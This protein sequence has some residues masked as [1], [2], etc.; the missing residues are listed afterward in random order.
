MSKKQ[1]PPIT[2]SSIIESHK[3]IDYTPPKGKFKK[4]LDRQMLGFPQ[5][6][7]KEDIY[8]DDCN[9]PFVVDIIDSDDNIVGNGKVVLEDEKY[10]MVIELPDKTIKEELTDLNDVVELLI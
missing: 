4:W 3:L 10:Y 9:S 8:I 5:V 2:A 7:T 1:T 6:I